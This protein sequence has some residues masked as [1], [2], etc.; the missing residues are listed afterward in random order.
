MNLLR[1]C[2]WWA[3]L[4]SFLFF[5]IKFPVLISSLLLPPSPPPPPLSLF[6]LSMKRAYA[7]ERKR[8]HSSLYSCYR[9]KM[10][11]TIVLYCNMLSCTSCWLLSFFRFVYDKACVGWCA[12]HQTIQ[13]KLPPHT[14]IHQL[15]TVYLYSKEIPTHTEVVW[16]I[17]V[18]VFAKFA[19]LPNTI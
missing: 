7:C 16:T 8:E 5:S 9:I 2:C 18:C 19:R 3:T 14:S 10:P 13:Y 15:V 17:H 11:A 12:V 6:S 1:Y 4:F